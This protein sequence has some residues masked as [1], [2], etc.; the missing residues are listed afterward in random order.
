MD[1]SRASF[2]PAVRSRSSEEREPQ[3]ALVK[4]RWLAQFRFF[5]PTLARTP[6][7]SQCDITSILTYEI[8]Q[9]ASV[10]IFSATLFLYSEPISLQDFSD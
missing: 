2:R 3:S 7:L 5:V 10:A 4:Q 1:L 8:P 6:L 9:S